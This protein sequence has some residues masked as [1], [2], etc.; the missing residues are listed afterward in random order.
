VR[1][2][3]DSGAQNDGDAAVEPLTQSVDGGIATANTDTTAAGAAGT[4]IATAGVSSRGVAE[5]THSEAASDTAAGADAE[6]AKASREQTVSIHIT[7]TSHNIYS[8]QCTVTVSAST[9]QH[10]TVLCTE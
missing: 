1:S 10:D 3:S 6:A 8:M 4:D 7:Y 9:Y 5:H 2:A